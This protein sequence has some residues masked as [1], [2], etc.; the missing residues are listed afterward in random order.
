[1]ST[2]AN[3]NEMGR[4]LTRLAEVTAN[5]RNNAEHMT[6]TL[7]AVNSNND[8]TGELVT[9]VA[10]AARELRLQSLKLAEQSSKFKLG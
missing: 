10:Q 2:E 6:S 7:S 8:K 9:Q 3:V 1:M 5:G 4:I